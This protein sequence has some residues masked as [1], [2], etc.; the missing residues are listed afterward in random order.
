MTRFVLILGWASSITKFFATIWHWVIDVQVARF[1]Q[2]KVEDGNPSAHSA[3]SFD[4]PDRQHVEYG[5]DIFENPF[6]DPAD[7]AMLREQDSFSIMRQLWKETN[8]G[9]CF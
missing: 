1:N 2:G 6:N 8:E 7:C 4:S 9:E 3:L 5:T